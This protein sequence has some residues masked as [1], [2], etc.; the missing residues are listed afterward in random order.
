M[1]IVA[2]PEMTLDRA[3]EINAALM[4][5][6]TSILLG[7]TYVP[8]PKGVSLEEMCVATRMIK[9]APSEETIH[10]DGHKTFTVTMRCDPRIT[11]AMYAFDNYGQSPTRLLE[12]FGFNAT[13]TDDQD[14]DEEDEG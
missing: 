6:A 11:A 3:K 1:L 5:S 9:E 10:E 8:L 14:D 4:R 2:A 7:P 13:A 12:A